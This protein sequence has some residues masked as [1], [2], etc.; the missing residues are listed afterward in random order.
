[1]TDTRRLPCA[2]DCAHFEAC[3]RLCKK[4]NC[5]YPPYYKMLG[6]NECEQYISRHDLLHW[7]MHGFDL[8]NSIFSAG[9]DEPEEDEVSVSDD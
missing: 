3:I 6:C 1:M 4:N 5:E 7:I 9:D 8:L 2:F